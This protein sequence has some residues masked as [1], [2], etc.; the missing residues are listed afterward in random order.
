M[1]GGLN[2]AIG[3]VFGAAMLAAGPASAT[4]DEPLIW[5]EVA[6]PDPNFVPPPELPAMPADADVPSIDPVPHDERN[7]DFEE[8]IRKAEAQIAELAA[9][10]CKALEQA[11]IPEAEAPSWSKECKR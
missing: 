1:A 4:P 8:A 2:I 11:E 5:S 10:A 3:F 9:A 7:G 6:D